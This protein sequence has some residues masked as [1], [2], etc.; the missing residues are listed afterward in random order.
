M[1]HMNTL[2]TYSVRSF[3][4]T[5][6]CLAALSAPAFAQDNEAAPAPPPQGQ[7]QG[8]RKG[9]EHQLEHLTRAL[10]LTPDQA[11]QVKAVMDSSRQQMMALRQDSSVEGPARY[12]RM[13]AIHQNEATGIEAVLNTDQKGKYQAMQAQ[14]QARRAEHEAQQGAQPQQPPQ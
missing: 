5:A 10:N 2:R 4:V 11:T 9:E 3:L 13:Q 8:H 6:A 14:M 1:N 7:Y 12:A